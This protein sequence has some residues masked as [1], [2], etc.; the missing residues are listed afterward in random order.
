MVSVSLLSAS[1]G[2]DGH[3]TL[4]TSAKTVPRP[5]TTSGFLGSRDSFLLCDV[6]G[7][8]QDRD[9]LLL[10][11]PYREEGV[12]GSKTNH[13]KVQG[14]KQGVTTHPDAKFKGEEKVKPEELQRG[15]CGCDVCGKGS[16]LLLTQGSGREWWRLDAQSGGRETAAG[17]NP[18]VNGR[19]GRKG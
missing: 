15:L 13:L 18:R 19:C 12:G 11:G 16:A 4:I 6:G 5:Q 7:A 17:S 1:S 9:Y 10:S 14:L 3:L 8:R 2:Q